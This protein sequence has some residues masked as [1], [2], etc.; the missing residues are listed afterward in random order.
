MRTFDTDFAAHIAGGMTTLCWCW[1]IVRTDGV[2]LGFTDHDVALAFEGQA[3]SPA[4]GLEGS[5]TVARLGAQTQTAEVLGVLTSEAIGEDDIALGRYDGARVES[6]RVNWRDVA[7]R[8]LIRADTIGEITREDGLFRAELRSAQHALNVPRGRLYQHMC[9]ARL[10]DGRCGVDLDDAAFRTQASVAALGDGLSVVVEGGAGFEPGW[11][12]HGTAR[13]TSGRR[14]GVA[15]AIIDHNGQR[16]TFARPVGDWVSAGDT[17]TLTAGC[18]RRFATCKAKFS[19][20]VNFRGFPHIPGNDYVLR[21]P[22]AEDRLD[23][24]RLVT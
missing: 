22:N 21:Y 12:A 23:G 5:E 6:W 4:H 18:D 14:S 8:A 20:A 3:F 2:R 24:R 19:N 1:L 7:Q 11:F 17:L 10:G 9:D 13:W 15:D 16:L